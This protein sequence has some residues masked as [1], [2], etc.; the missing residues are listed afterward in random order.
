MLY[1]RVVDFNCVLDVDRILLE[2]ILLVF[3]C[4]AFSDFIIQTFLV[5]WYIL[6]VS[7]VLLL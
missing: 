4:S 3:C 1:E 2:V 5:V 7:Y 6:F